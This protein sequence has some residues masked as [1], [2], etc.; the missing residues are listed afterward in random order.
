MEMMVLDDSLFLSASYIFIEAGR[1]LI[2][3]GSTSRSSLMGKIAR[4][5]RQRPTM[6]PLCIRLHVSKHDALAT[7]GAGRKKVKEK[8]PGG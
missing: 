2:N 6:A 3:V 8:R 7:R 1:N 4:C 5:R